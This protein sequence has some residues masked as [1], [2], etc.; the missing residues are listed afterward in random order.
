MKQSISDFVRKLSRLVLVL[1]EM[2]YIIQ[3]AEVRAAKNFGLQRFWSFRF[4]ANFHVPYA[5]RIFFHHHAVGI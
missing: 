4:D 2:L 1:A 3:K 5:L